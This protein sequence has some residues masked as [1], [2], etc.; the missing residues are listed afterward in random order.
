MAHITGFAGIRCFCWLQ[1]SPR[2]PFLI[3]WYLTLLVIPIFVLVSFLLSLVSRRLRLW[4][5]RKRDKEEED[6]A[7]MLWREQCTESEDDAVGLCLSSLT[8]AVLRYLI[9]GDLPQLHGSVTG[10]TS[11]EA[12]GLSGVG[13][14]FA[15]LVSV[16][17]YKLNQIG[18]QEFEGEVSFYAERPVKIFQIW[19]GLTM[20]WCLYFATQ[21]RF[22]AVLEANKSILHGCAGKLLQAVLLTFCCM[23][24]I[25]VLD[26][27]GDGSEKCKKAFNGVITALG[28]L[29]GISWEG[30]FTLAIDEIV[31]NHPQNRL[32]LK[33]LLA[34]G[35]V[36]VVV[37]AWRLYIL[38]R[39]DPEIM[40][41][42]KGRMP[43]LV[44]LWRPWDPVKDYKESKMER[45]MRESIDLQ[46]KI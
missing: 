8:S 26:C 12:L 2:F 7:D 43:P 33:N 10:R 23:L 20:S 4:W 39:S 31:A 24:V 16:A 17:T 28:L 45:R 22:L 41:Y 44:A 25:F 21:W 11:A 15:V 38:P 34:F 14:L 30:S 32:L 3:S 40:S 27:L 42:Y 5:V 36:L 35:L 37:P 46:Q 9:S 1:I 19:A 18:Q 13:L 6:E 29:V